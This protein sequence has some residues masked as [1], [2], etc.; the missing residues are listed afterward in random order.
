M[1]QTIKSQSLHPGQQAVFFEKP[2]ALSR[3]F[4]G[5]SALLPPANNYRS[6]ISFDDPMF[7]TYYTL[8]GSTVYFEAKGEGIFQG[9]VW[10]RNESTISITYSISEILV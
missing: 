3:I 7:Y 6:K 1:A 9:N 4:I 10:V 8:I 2:H 5:I